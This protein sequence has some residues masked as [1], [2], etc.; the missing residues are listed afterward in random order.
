M[1]EIFSKFIHH[2]NNGFPIYYRSYTSSLCFGNKVP[3]LLFSFFA[4][5]INCEVALYVVTN[6]YA[7]VAER[8]DGSRW[9]S[10]LFHTA[11]CHRARFETGNLSFFGAP[12]LCT[13]NID[14]DADSTNYHP[15]ADCFQSIESISAHQIHRNEPTRSR[16]RF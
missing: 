7:L 1:I 2:A 14:S 3:P 9:D 12:M 8:A 13:H 4:L 11:F 6:Y 15:R 10:D 16:T 5:A